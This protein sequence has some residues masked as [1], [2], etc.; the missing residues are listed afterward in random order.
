VSFP[1]L[2]VRLFDVFDNEIFTWP[3]W[4]LALYFTDEEISYSR[5]IQL[6]E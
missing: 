2:K 6:C 4:N 1:L 5:R 3:E